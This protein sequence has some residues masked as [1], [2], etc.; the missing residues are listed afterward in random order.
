MKN[1]LKLRNGLAIA[2][3][4]KRF[5]YDYVYNVRTQSSGEMVCA[6]KFNEQQIWLANKIIDHSL[7]ILKIPNLYQSQV[8]I[9]TISICNACTHF[10][11]AAKW[12]LLY[13]NSFM[14]MYCV[15][16]I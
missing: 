9:S 2:R 6:E 16:V 8:E 7:L 1:S 11:V 15:Q 10:N 12:N 13:H 5:L 4:K 3:E 14:S